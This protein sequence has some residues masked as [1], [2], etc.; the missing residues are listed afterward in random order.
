MSF[1]YIS[2]MTTI[3]QVRA[4]VATQKALLPAIYGGIDFDADPERFTRD[5][6]DAVVQDRAPM[7]VAVTAV[8]A[9]VT[10]S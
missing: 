7:G 5:P 2:A 3:E 1:A 8:P 10:M 9:M 4:K 6:K